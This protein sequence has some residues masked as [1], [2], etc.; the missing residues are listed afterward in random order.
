MPRFEA[1]IVI[2]NYN[3]ADLLPRCLPSIEKAVKTAKVPIAVTLLDNL[4]QDNG[5]KYAA[6]H[7]PEFTRV[8]SR[9]NRV[10]C[11]YNDY[12]RQITEPVVILLNNDIRVDPG[13]VDPL[14]A[15]FQTDPEVFL[16][17]PR[18]MSFDGATVEAGASKAG[19]AFGLFWC[20]A[21][22]QGYE[23]DVL[24][25][26]DTFSSGFG[27][28]S[29]EKFLALGSYD[30]LYLPGI[31]EDV[32]LCYR[33]RKAGYRLYYEPRSVVYHMGQASFKKRYCTGRIAEI[34]WRNTFL[35]MWKNFSGLRFWLIHLSGLPV[36]MLAELLRGRV[37]LIKGLAEALRLKIQ[38]CFR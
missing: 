25:P 8:S 32:D 28:V 31:M 9:A 16:V 3:G 21:R 18:V 17:A 13:F 4:S 38:Q 7:F 19:M 23:A 5:M 2:L 24:T 14:V 26:S 35:F 1:R 37:A 33:A 11:S 30:D 6:S 36:R 10:L 22:Y 20:N 27:A 29:R 15:R 12:L 34:G